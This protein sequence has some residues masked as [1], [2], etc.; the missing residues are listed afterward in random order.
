MRRL[1]LNF[2]EAQRVLLQLVKFP[3]TVAVTITTA[4]GYIL[5]SGH[6][7]TGLWEAIAGVFLLACGC[8]A[9]NEAQEWRIDALMRRTCF[10]PIPSGR[11]GLFSAVFIALMLI[12]AGLTIL[13]WLAP[14][15]FG[16]GVFSVFWYNGVYTYL[17][18]LTVFAVIPG[19]FIGAV[20]PAIGWIAAGGAPGEMRILSLCLFLFIWQAPHFWLLLLMHGE[21]YERAGL[22]TLSRALPQR[23]LG[24]FTYL[25]ILLAAF[26]GFFLS[27]YGMG[28]NSSGLLIILFC[29]AL[30]LIGISIKTLRGLKSERL[31]TNFFFLNLY[32]LIVFIGVC[33]NRIAVEVK[34]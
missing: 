7:A 34:W 14:G 32:A 33:A 19:A 27:R 26:A 3:I 11:M 2:I 23:S 16:L 6:F 17:K 30:F 4:A 29:A 1:I 13:W 8:S 22:P 5:Y 20:P 10:R 21:D 25:W 24:L 12:C 31:P 9:L 15:A 28:V 18:R